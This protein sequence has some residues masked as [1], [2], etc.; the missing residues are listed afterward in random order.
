MFVAR[1]EVAALEM[2]DDDDDDE[3]QC[4]F[5]LL[6]MLIGIECQF[7]CCFILICF[8]YNDDDV[9]SIDKHN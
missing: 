5:A 8:I 1:M 6:L 4:I 2:C 3:H 9:N 7:N